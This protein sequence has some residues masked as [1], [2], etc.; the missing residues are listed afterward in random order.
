MIEVNNNSLIN[1]GNDICMVMFFN[2]DFIY[3]VRRSLVPCKSVV[4]ERNDKLQPVAI[5][6]NGSINKQYHREYI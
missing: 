1:N 3:V 2:L 5:N 6:N 4:D